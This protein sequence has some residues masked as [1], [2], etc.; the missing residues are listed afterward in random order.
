[1]TMKNFSNYR[2]EKD[3]TIISLRRKKIPP[4]IKGG[5]NLNRIP[6]YDTREKIIKP[7]TF[8]NSGYL[9]V[10]ITDDNGKQHT[11]LIHR[12]VAEEHI[13]NPENKPQVNHKDGDKHNNHM[14]NLEWVTSS[15]NARHAFDKGLKIPRKGEDRPTAKLTNEQAIELIND[16]KL[17][18][19]TTQLATKYGL[20]S[21]YVSLIRHKK[22]WKHIW[23]FLEL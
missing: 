1:M 3:G 9:R 11:K 21:R 19:T 6:V 16:I 8:Q 12:L 10:N 23:E 15:E 13:P 17:G 2:I 14:D 7:L 22:R 5:R 20:H 4:Y 18:A